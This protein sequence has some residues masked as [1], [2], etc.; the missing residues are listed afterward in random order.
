VLAEHLDSGNAADSGDPPERQIRPVGDPHE[1]F[2]NAIAAAKRDVDEIV[3]D[4]PEL[5]INDAVEL[6]SRKLRALYDT[7]KI[8]QNKEPPSV[9]ENLSVLRDCALAASVAVK[10]LKDEESID[11]MTEAFKYME[12]FQDEAQAVFN[13]YNSGNR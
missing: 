5:P 7:V 6:L 2:L 10:R 13:F 9:G 3:A 12:R 1:E 8:R 4:F 11:R